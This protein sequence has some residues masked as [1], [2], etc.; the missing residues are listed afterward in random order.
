MTAVRTLL[1]A[2]ADARMKTAS[3][4]TAAFFAR[5]KVHAAVAAMLT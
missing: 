1:D 4:K 3:G 5:G 2:G